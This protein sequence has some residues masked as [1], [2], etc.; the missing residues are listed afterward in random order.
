MT[1]TQRDIIQQ[2]TKQLEFMGG[3]L[4]AWDMDAIEFGEAE[5]DGIFYMIE[6]IRK[7]L[8]TLQKA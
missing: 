5:K 8:Q 4:L 6:C 7:E 2:S 3:M 1:Q